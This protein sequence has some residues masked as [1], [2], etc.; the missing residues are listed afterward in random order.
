MLSYV[1]LS[2]LGQDTWSRLFFGG[3]ECVGHSFAYVA[4]FVFS[5]DVWIRIQRAAVASGRATNV[6]AHLPSPWSK[7]VSKKI[8]LLIRTKNKFEYRV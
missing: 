6:A 4:H 3:L 2:I 7:L 5:G 8:T 1:D